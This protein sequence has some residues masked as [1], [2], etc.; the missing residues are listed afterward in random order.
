MA[1]L[2]NIIK[3]RRSIRR[4]Q[5]KEIPAEVLQQLLESIQWSP[6]WANTQCW[7]VIVVKDA[8]LKSELAGTLPGGNP[9]R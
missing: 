7:E 6:S 8:K 1:D 2:M 9:A 4:Y 5:E 3:G